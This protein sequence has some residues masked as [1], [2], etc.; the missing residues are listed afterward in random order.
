MK[1]CKFMVICQCRLFGMRNVSDQ[2]CREK[3][4]IHFEFNILLFVNRVLC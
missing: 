1:S 4:E 2:I 3:I